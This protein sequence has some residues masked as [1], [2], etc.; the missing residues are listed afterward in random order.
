[1][2][3]TAEI[4]NLMSP[5]SLNVIKGC[6][7]PKIDRCRYSSG[8][9]GNIHC[10]SWIRPTT[11]L[12]REIISCRCIPDLTLADEVIIYYPPVYTTPV[13]DAPIR[14]VVAGRVNTYGSQVQRKA[15]AE[16]KTVRNF[17]LRLPSSPSFLEDNKEKATHETQASELSTI[18]PLTQFT[19][20][21]VCPIAHE[22]SGGAYVVEH[23]ALHVKGGSDGWGVHK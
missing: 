16:A 17:D 22:P 20:D 21:W 3:L 12:P 18:V 4:G 11:G 10:Q 19:G 8:M 7:L 5:G 1:M 2:R 15:V 23:G 14:I 6:I 13:A 9:L